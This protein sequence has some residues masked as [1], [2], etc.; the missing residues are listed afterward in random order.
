VVLSVVVLLM[1]G[2][3]VLII[4]LSI[5]FGERL[6]KKNKWLAFTIFSLPII[7]IAIPIVAFFYVFHPSTPESLS[8]AV[9]ERSPGAYAIEGKWTERADFYSYPKDVIVFC[10]PSQKGDVEID[11]PNIANVN[12]SYIDYAAKEFFSQKLNKNSNCKGF[13]AELQKGYDIP[14]KLLNT[15]ASD[16]EAYFIHQVN[17]PMDSPRHWYKKIE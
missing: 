16:L 8:L 5:V 9:K 7:I 17:E 14:F 11:L 15:T 12:D 1:S 13:V 4:T 10:F 2:I 3:C 6:L